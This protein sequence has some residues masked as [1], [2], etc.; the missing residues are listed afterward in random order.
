MKNI[1]FTIFLLMPTLLF[2]Q[3]IHFGDKEP[4]SDPDI[5]YYKFYNGIQ[6]VEFDYL[7]SYHRRVNYLEQAKPRA[8]TWAMVLGPPHSNVYLF[9][10]ENGEIVKCFGDIDSTS[11]LSV[12]ASLKKT[13]YHNSFGAQFGSMLGFSQ[14]STRYF[15]YYLIGNTSDFV[16]NSIGLIDSLGNIV[17]KQEYHTIWKHDELFITRKDSI[18]ELRDW[19]LNVKYSTT[20]FLLQPAQFHAGCADILKDEKCGLI[21]ANGKIIVPCEYDM[22]IDGFNEIG[23][24]KVS[25]KRLIGYANKDGKEVIKCKYQSV[26]YFKEGLLDAR[27]NEKWGY[28]DAEGNTVI[29]FKY[30]IGIWFEEGLARVAKRES[31]EFYFGYIDKQGNEVIPLIYSNAKDFMDGKAEVM[32]DGKWIKIDKKGLKQ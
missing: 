17:L 2:A 15:P 21:D 4:T 7:S 24:A 14:I 20:T 8:L 1:I 25:K 3:V 30:D 32:K 19:N 9:R 16:H 18:N 13:Q 29:P 27:Y 6:M 5:H 23:L 10:K 28:I 22:L 26:G 12:E 11:L 31:G